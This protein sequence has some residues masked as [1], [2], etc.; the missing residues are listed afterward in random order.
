[1]TDAARAN[2]LEME[3]SRFDNTGKL[4]HIRQRSYNRYSLE[5]KSLEA[6]I[7]TPIDADYT[8]DM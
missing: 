8:T 6:K 2:A 3:E 4:V 7:H 5:A 1:M